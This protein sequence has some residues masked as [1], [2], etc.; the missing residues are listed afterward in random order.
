[1]IENG[2]RGA[3]WMALLFVLGC[4]PSASPY[5]AV[6]RE[7]IAAY[8]EMVAI[9]KGVTDSETMKAA[10]AKLE[11]RLDAFD[12]IARRAQSLAQPVPADVVEEL[13]D[14]QRRL[15]DMVPR[16]QGEVRRI[17]SLTGGREFLQQFPSFRGLI[18]KEAP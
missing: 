16:V 4:G 14:E 6:L 1:V 3:G 11:E 17:L 15:V 13:R 9:L 2:M 10:Q 5:R 8:E 7:Q 18:T 12:D